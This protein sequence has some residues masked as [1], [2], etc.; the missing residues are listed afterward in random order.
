VAIIVRNGANSSIVMRTIIIGDV[1]GCLDEL[2]DL[3]R[4]CGGARE[5]HIVLV[6]DLVAKGPDSAGV[7]EWAREEGARAVLGNHD[8]HLLRHKPGTARS[9]DDERP[10]HASVA[11][12]LRQDDWRWLEGLPLWIAL[13]KA[14]DDPLASPGAVVVHAGVV[15]GIPLAEQKREHLLTLRSFAADGRPSKRVEGAPWASRWPG[16]SHVV[17]G[18]DAVRG[19]Q[20]WR[21]ATGLDTGCVYGGM[22]TALVL[23]SGELVSV[24][25]RRAYAKPQD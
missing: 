6:G 2:R 20:R 24:T 14:S 23:P 22:L 10:H 8:A 11:R 17:F 4:Q 15:P 5:A 13:G 12:T 1:H 25:A 18:H 19:L 7:I 3:V 16:P 9:D 21:H